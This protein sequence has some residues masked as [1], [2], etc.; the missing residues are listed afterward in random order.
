MPDTVLMS[1]LLK[2][3]LVLFFAKR[4]QGGSVS[5]SG[6]QTSGSTTFPVSFSLRVRA[7]ANHNGTSVAA[8]GV[9][10]SSTTITAYY[11]S[12]ASSVRS[13]NYIAIGA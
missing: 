9:S 8:I 5:V 2:C 6:G 12:S 7:T 11:P 1:P 4:S 10:A 3:L 13:V